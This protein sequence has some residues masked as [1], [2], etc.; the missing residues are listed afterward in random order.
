MTNH[1]TSQCHCVACDKRRESQNEWYKKNRD[2]R[3]LYSRGWKQVNKK[4][5]NAYMRKY[6]REK[7]LTEPLSKTPDAIAD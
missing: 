4:K 5:Y 1:N 2:S 3:R 6:M 7:R